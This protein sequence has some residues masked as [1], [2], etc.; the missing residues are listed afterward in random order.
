MKI[1]KLE[2]TNRL[3]LGGLLFGFGAIVANSAVKIIPYGSDASRLTASVMPGFLY[4]F[5]LPLE[6]E[7]IQVPDYSFDILTLGVIVATTGFWIVVYDRFQRARPD[8]R[9]QIPTRNP[10]TAPFSRP[11][12]G[13]RLDYRY[14]GR[15]RSPAEY[16]RF[17]D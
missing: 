17:A 7:V 15:Y 10:D 13:H 3:I 12:R 8:T 14:P 6:Y 11:P 9:S 1:Y 4:P 2:I 5:W 16:R